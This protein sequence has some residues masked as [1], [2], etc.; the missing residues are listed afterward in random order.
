MKVYT[1]TG[2]SG[3][4]TLMSGEK[5][6]KFSLSI[7]VNGEL[8]ELNACL[9]IIKAQCQKIMPN[10]E[11][12]LELYQKRIMEISA[13]IAGASQ[14]REDNAS[15]LKVTKLINE[16]E[17]AIDAMNG[18]LPKLQS[19]VIPGAPPLSAWIHWTRAVCRRAERRLVRFVNEEGL[20]K[21]YQHSLM[22]VNRLSDYLFVLARTFQYYKKTPKQ[23]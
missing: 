15:D 17:S 16:M 21:E 22:F 14:K 9:G 6:D 12:D 7:E 4:T 1:K 10:I 20:K 18:S 11:K 3:K 13:K 19:F 23:K 8:D 2:D 5:V